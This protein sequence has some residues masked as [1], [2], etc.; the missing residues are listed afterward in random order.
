M[1]VHDQAH[2]EN[3]IEDGVVCAARGKRRDGK[4]YEAGGENALE[5]PVVRAMGL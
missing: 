5:R 3:A 1:T 2:A 4:G